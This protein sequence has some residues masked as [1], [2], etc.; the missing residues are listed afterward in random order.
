M[1]LSFSRGGKDADLADDRASRIGR[2]ERF[3]GEPPNTSRPRMSH[4]AVWPLTGTLT[5]NPNRGTVR[6]NTS[7]FK[8]W[9]LGNGTRFSESC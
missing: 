3:S 9:E 5:R 8:P 2:V 1:G 4:R 7:F 6:G